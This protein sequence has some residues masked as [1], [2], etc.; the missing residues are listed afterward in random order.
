LVLGRLCSHYT[1]YFRPLRPIH[2]ARPYT[3]KLS[4]FVV[5]TGAN[6]V[7]NNRRQS[8]AIL[9]SLTEL[10]PVGY[11]VSGPACVRLRTRSS[12]WA[13]LSSNYCE[14][15][16]TSDYLSATVWSR[17]ESSAC[18]N[19]TRP[20]ATRRDSLSHFS[21]TASRIMYR[22]VGCGRGDGRH[23]GHHRPSVV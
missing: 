12:G 17:R 4:N 18:V 22:V 8:V 2:T 19:T 20:D 23:S 21:H 16:Q 5:S 13:C 15:V 14:H 3:T 1:F 10:C 6:W 11:I 7:G 9:N